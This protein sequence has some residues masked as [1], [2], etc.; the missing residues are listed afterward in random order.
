MNSHFLANTVTI[1]LLLTAPIVNA[2]HFH[3]SCYLVDDPSPTNVISATA[4]SADD[5]TSA[6]EAFRDL[7]G[8][9][10]NGND[11]NSNLSGHRQINWDASIVPFEMPGDFFANTVTRGCVISTTD[12]GDFRVSNPSPDSGVQDDSFDS[13]VGDGI[14]SQFLRFSDFRLFSPYDD[15]VFYINFVDPGNTDI[16]AKVNGFGAIFADVDQFG[17]SKL[18]FFDENGCLLAAEYVK[19]EP[20]GLSFLGVNFGDRAI[21]ATVKVTL[22]HIAIGQVHADL[23][24]GLR[25]AWRRLDVAVM[26]DFL[27]GEPQVL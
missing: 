12:D 23:Q 26:D 5:L 14:A 1:T 27:Y 20:S 18:E 6:F 19:P 2:G 7:L 8:G 21:V 9:Q 24:G 16:T 25:H 3:P 13:I 22:G 10:N 17:S 15:N 4:D 11:P